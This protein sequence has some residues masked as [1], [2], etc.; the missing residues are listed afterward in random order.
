VIEKASGESY[1]RFLRQRIF[2]PLGMTNSGI[3]DR[4]QIVPGLV[5]VY[6]IRNGN[7][8]PW[9]RDWQYEVNAFAGVR[10]TVGDLA[11]W[12]AALR[13]DNLLKRES[14]D[15]MWTPAKLANGNEAVLFGDA[16]GFGWTL[17][18]LRGHRTVEHAGASG[19]YILRVLDAGLTVLVLTNLDVTAGSQ[20]A[21]LARGVAGLIKKELRAPELLTAQVDPAPQTTLAIKGLLSDMA[22]DRDPPLMTAGHRAFYLGMPAPVRADNSGLLKTLR[23]F[24]YLA[25]DDVAGRGLTRWGE[26]VTRIA[27]YKGELEGRPFYFTFWL[28]AD[29]KVANLRFYPGD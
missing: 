22:D 21:V 5:P 4:W 18:E 25:A 10:A 13:S 7:L 12:D 2:E 3:V 8:A 11:R 27:Y 26:P 17:G 16:Y 15:R 20:P 9:R 24:S 28:T 6:T 23:S 19:T 29:S 14:R 1:D